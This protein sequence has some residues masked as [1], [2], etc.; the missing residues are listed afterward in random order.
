MTTRELKVLSII[1]DWG[2]EA[3]VNII[4]RAAGISVDYA[5]LLCESLKREN[6]IDFLNFKLCRMRGKGKL[7][8]VKR[9]KKNLYSE[10][11]IRTSR[12]AK[13][14][15]RP[16]KIVVNRNSIGLGRNKRGR[17]TLNY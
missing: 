13:G 17:L 8:V 4:A 16:S 10:S 3:S 9:A 7:Q 1:W 6:Y 14:E 5:R 12:F 11:S 15:N 2:G